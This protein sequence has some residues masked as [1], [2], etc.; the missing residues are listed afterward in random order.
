MTT[1][2]PR[3]NP[4]DAA[5][6]VA[7]RPASR[8]PRR[9]GRAAFTLTEV[10]VASALST[11][12]LAGILSTF[13]LIGRTGLTAAAYADMN[14]TVRHALERFNHDVRHASDVRWAGS[15][16][17]T[18]LPAPGAGPAV[19]YAYEPA[20]NSAAPGRFV[21]LIDGAAP[22]VLVASVAPD[23]AF[24][25][26]RLP[27]DALNEPPPA[28]N[29]FETKQLQVSMRAVRV[30]G[31]LPAVSQLALSARNVMRNKTVGQ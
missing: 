23:F 21:R 19:T 31:G 10:M 15:R 12:V 16:R 17:L 11:F 30:T 3:V 9:V 8:P 5:R 20:A 24:S 27:D 26:Y 6:L 1:S 29:D 13:L 4:S 14:T 28:A 22:E 25:R 2:T 7:A 18:L